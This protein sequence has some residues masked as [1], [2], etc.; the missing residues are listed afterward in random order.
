[1][2]VNVH[3]E[4]ELTLRRLRE[5]L[6]LITPHWP[7]YP[8]AVGII[9]GDF[10]ICEPEEGRFNVWNQTFTDGDAGKT[11]I[12]HPFFP[13]VL[14]IAQPDYTWTDSTALGIIA[15]S[16]T[17]QWL[18]REMFTATPMSSRIC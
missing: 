5:R 6:R 4:P 1:M 13:R 7:S 8:N 14:E 15:F 2:I 10:N 11:A 16:L 17:H 12:F 18:R 3:F 9:L